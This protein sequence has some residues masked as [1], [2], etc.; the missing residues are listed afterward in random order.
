ME[1]KRVSDRRNAGGGG[2][3][4]IDVDIIA[5]PPAPCT[6]GKQGIQRCDGA[7]SSSLR[8][9]GAKGS[10]ETQFPKEP[11]RR[12]QRRLDL[13]LPLLISKER[14]RE[15]ESNQP[16]SLSPPLPRARAS[17]APPARALSGSRSTSDEPCK[18]PWCFVVRR[19]RE[20]TQGH[21]RL[22][23]KKEKKVKEE[24]EF[25]RFFFGLDLDDAL[26]PPL[27][28][29]FS[30]PAAVSWL[31]LPAEQRHIKFSFSLSLSK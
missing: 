3:S 21:A 7:L 26:S 28:P 9:L 10:E 16:P 30:L 23:N 24:A 4:M 31:T 1:C 29:L 13:S 22:E 12:R 5:S 19:F 6:A 27:P 18:R 20:G 8:A 17:L 2:G 15:Q 11:R 25:F 14:G